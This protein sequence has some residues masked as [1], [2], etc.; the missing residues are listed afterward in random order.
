MN[1]AIILSG[2]IGTRMRS[3]GFPK[4]YLMVNEKP[5]LLYALEPFAACRQ[6]DRIV[7]VANDAWKEQIQQWVKDAGIEK[8]VDIAPNGDCRQASI[9]NGLLAC[10][11]YKA[12]TA[13]DKVLIHD[14]VRPLVTVKLIE[15]CLD[16]LQRYDC[17]LPAVPIFDSTY[18]TQDHATVFGPFNRD[19]LVCG[20][21]P[22]GF[23][24]KSY[25]ELNQACTPE[26]LEKLRGSVELPLQHGLTIGLVQGDH[27][28]FKLTR[29]DDLKLFKAH[30][31][32]RA[33]EE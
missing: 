21:T 24:L 5:V 20:Q 31:A 15:D 19:K 17:C 18:T 33:M 9:L 14:G 12:P 6:I 30:L 22:E 32:A 29:P 1:Y 23:E 16:V 13:E 26:E 25:L 27:N 7:I 3:D 8:P 11:A 2:G 4:Q 10:A 28:N